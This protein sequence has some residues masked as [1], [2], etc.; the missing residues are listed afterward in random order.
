MWKTKKLSVILLALALTGCS[1]ARPEAGAPAGSEDRFVGFYVVR[2]NEDFFDNPNL[3]EYGASVLETGAY[4]SFCVPNQVLFGVEEDGEYVFPGLTGYRLFRLKGTAED[5]TRYSRFYS[6]MG[7]G[8]NTINVTDYGTK[9][10]LSGTLYVGPPLGAEDW[11]VYEDD[12]VWRLY[13]VFQAADGRPYLIGSGNSCV[14]SFGSMTEKQTYASTQ[15][16][17]VAGEDSVE[18]TVVMETAS[19]LERLVV[20]E[21]DA[22]NSI[23][24]TDEVALDPLPELQCG[25]E[26]AWV[27]VEEYGKDSVKRTIYNAPGPEDESIAHQIVLLDDEGMGHLRWLEIS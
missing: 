15:N 7:P 9:E 6:D 23:L 21:F 18:V 14:G 8:E 1:L 10:V 13:R 22:K 26:T 2:A 11:D 5:G 24:R 20:T 16:G 27:L 25:A 12:S 17:T 3:V 19:R 4:G